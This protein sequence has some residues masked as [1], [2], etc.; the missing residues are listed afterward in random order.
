MMSRDCRV[1]QRSVIKFLCVRGAMPIQCWRKL[2][3]VYGEAALRKTQV[4]AWHKR[5]KEGDIDTATKDKPRPGRPR[6]G[7]SAVKINLVDNQLQQDRR[8]SIRD[9]SAATQI[10]RATVQRIIRKDLSLRHV[11]CKFVPRVLTQEQKD[12]RVRMCQLNLDQFEEEG[13][14]FLQ[15]II[16]GDESSLHTFEPE[17]KIHDTQWIRPR[18]K[19]P[20]KALRACTWQSTMMTTFFDCNGIMHHE[21]LARGATMRSEDYCEVLARLREKV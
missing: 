4:R 3:K 1:E 8:Q 15:R 12:F 2:S 6:S 20:R 21:F 10:P 18:D 13:V 7:R 9:V 5:F 17:T 19:R 14:S 16:T 11:S